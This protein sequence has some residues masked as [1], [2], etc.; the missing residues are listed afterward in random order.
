MCF[1]SENEEI[2]IILITP[3][4]IAA[5]EKRERGNERREREREKK[6]ERK[7]ERGGGGEDIFI[8]DEKYIYYR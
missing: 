1:T 3:W 8:I 5:A 6:R 7:R 4:L 2:Q